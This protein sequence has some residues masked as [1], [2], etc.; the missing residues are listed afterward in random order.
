[1]IPHQTGVIILPA[2]KKHCFWVKILPKLPW[3][4]INSDP[5]KM[6]PIWWSLR[7]LYHLE[8][9]W[10]NSHV[11][12]CNTPLRFA[13]FWE[14]RHLLSLWCILVVQNVTSRHLNLFGFYSSHSTPFSR[15]NFM[16]P[17]WV[18]APMPSG[19]VMDLHSARCSGFF[20]FGPAGKSI[21]FRKI[22]S[23]FPESRT[24]IFSQSL[25]QFLLA[26]CLDSKMG[27]NTGGPSQVVCGNSHIPG[28]GQLRPACSLV[29]WRVGGGVDIF[30]VENGAYGKASY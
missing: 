29:T 22:F 20:R 12:V 21:L 13:T 9:R 25:S 8:S 1:M 16:T 27:K 14:L 2:Q 15:H 30:P 4:C 26:F 3:I 24:H 17:A 28:D 7:N 11:L 23:A 10:R 6:G 18:S 5:S 19:V